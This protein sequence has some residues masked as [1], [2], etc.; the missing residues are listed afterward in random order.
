MNFDKAYLISLKQSE[1][2]RQRFYHRAVAAQMDVQWIPAVYGLDVNISTYQTVGYL[3]KDFNL[4]MAG[5]LGTLLSHIQIWDIIAADE[6]CE[7]GLVFEDDAIVA[8]NFLKKIKAIPE[9][10]LPDDWDMLWLAWHK[11]DLEKVNKWWGRPQKSSKGGVN[12]G[13]YAYI[14]R[15]E[16]VEKLKSIVLPYN[17]KNS[18]DVLLRKNFKNFGAYFLLKKIARTPW[19]DFGSV[20]KKIN[21]PKRNPFLDNWLGKKIRKFSK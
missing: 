18:K 15:R 9:E 5:S 6:S 11:K 3:S 17:N 21:N 12:S 7:R 13:H 14:I 4:K 16:S 8:K 2:R 20:R 10:S 1:K 19:V